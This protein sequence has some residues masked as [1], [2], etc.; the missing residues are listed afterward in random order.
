MPEGFLAQ[1]QRLKTTRPV[2]YR[3][4]TLDLYVERSEE[5]F[6]VAG[7]LFLIQG[8]T[9]AIASIQ[10]RFNEPSADQL[11]LKKLQALTLPFYQFFV[12]NASQSVG[13]AR[14]DGSYKA[15]GSIKAEGLE[16]KKMTYLI[17]TP[18]EFIC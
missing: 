8:A 14:A 15:D 7:S 4:A 5:L 16:R 12:S 2:L 9:D 17:Y 6:T 18:E 1:I 13:P 11:S 3:T 10:V